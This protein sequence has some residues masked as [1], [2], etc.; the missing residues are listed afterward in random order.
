MIK[1][2]KQRV[3][4]VESVYFELLLIIKNPIAHFVRFA[5]SCEVFFK[6]PTGIAPPPI[7][8]SSRVYHPVGAINLNLKQGLL[9]SCSNHCV[10]NDY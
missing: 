9:S 7:R 3:R 1:R 5:A 8:A 4:K 6:P 10:K 2:V